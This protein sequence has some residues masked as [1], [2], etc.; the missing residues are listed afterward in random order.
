MTFIAYWVIALAVSL[1]MNEAADGVLKSL[2]YGPDAPGCSAA[3]AVNGR[4]EW[5]G[6]AGSADVEHAVPIDSS[7][8]FNAGS[9]AKS[10]TGLAVMLLEREGRLSLD[11]S[12]T[13]YVT[14]L[15]AAYESVRIR[16]L[17]SH[18]SGVRDWQD[19]LFNMGSY[20]R[21]DELRETDVLSALKLQRGLNFPPGTRVQYSNSNYILLGEV[22]RAVSGLSLSDFARTRIFE[23]LGMRHSR[24]VD[25]HTAIIPRVAAA[26]QKNDTGWELVP[27][28]WDL[29]GPSD[30]YTTADDLVLFLGAV[31][32]PEWG[33]LFRRME[34]VASLDDG[35]PAA[36]DS[37]R[38]AGFGFWSRKH[39][40]LTL[41]GHSG[42]THGTRAAVYQV[43]E[44]SQTVAVL[45]NHNQIDPETAAMRLLDAFTNAGW[46]KSLDTTPSDPGSAAPRPEERRFAGV[47]QQPQTRLPYRI[48][49]TETGL[50]FGRPDRP[51]QPLADG[52]YTLADVP[53]SRVSFRES[54]GTTHMLLLNGGARE[55]EPYDR[56]S[57]EW[58]YQATPSD[59]GG[60]SGCY[61]SPELAVAVQLRAG[62]N[63]A[64]ELID[65]RGRVRKFNAAL[66]DLWRGGFDTIEFDRDANGN[67]K[68]F[69]RST[70]IAW[71][72]QYFRRPCNGAPPGAP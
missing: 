36:D 34:A 27:R 10:V 3:Y 23:P 26:H 14:G 57:N 20:R 43:R 29:V 1:P 46:T 28:T 44:Q 72:V 50:A 31:R 67:V 61:A 53:G 7:T 58:R 18:S 62:E 48:L 5:S 63:A 49:A 52:S 16:H 64:L 11:D 66:R 13:K 71:R 70:E 55:L 19:L 21:D 17:L 40:G 12:V 68:G 56:V 41:V 65:P 32:S 38:F 30:L 35:A 22:V 47:Y 37:G 4:I 39:D 69:A 45:C 60:V 24:V 25:D 9:I 42:V 6:V 51:L 33:D 59:T 54:G 8:P 2:T 15:P